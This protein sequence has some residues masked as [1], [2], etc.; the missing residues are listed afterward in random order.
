VKD[1]GVGA[2]DSSDGAPVTTIVGGNVYNVGVGS[3]VSSDGVE[4]IRVVGF[5]V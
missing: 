5:E 4:V 3:N 2:N 1:V